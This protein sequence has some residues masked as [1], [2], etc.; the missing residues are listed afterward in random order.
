MKIILISILLMCSA[1]MPA[2]HKA[3]SRIINNQIEY[4]DIT[5]NP[6][7]EEISFN[8]LANEFPEKYL[9]RTSRLV[10]MDNKEKIVSYNVWKE[11]KLWSSN[12][13]SHS[14]YINYN[15]TVNYSN[16][17]CNIKYSD[18]SYCESDNIS[19][20]GK[21]INKDDVLDGEFIL[22]DKKYRSLTK[23][24]LNELVVEK[25]ESHFN[26]MTKGLYDLL[27]EAR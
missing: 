20:N 14:I 4:N 25:T 9:D 10:A 3:E 17:H 11:L 5:G 1:A 24:N 7:N 13:S 19:E 23:K 8:I 15:M 18:I 2:E 22:V 6:V 27:S 16:M 21:I 26:S 12:F